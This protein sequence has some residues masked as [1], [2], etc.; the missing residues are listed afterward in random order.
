MGTNS[1]SGV[2]GARR[3]TQHTDTAGVAPARRAATPPV[4]LLPQPVR[5]FNAGAGG[6]SGTTSVT[7]VNKVRNEMLEKTTGGKLNLNPEKLKGDGKGKVVGED[8]AV[9][10]GDEVSFLSDLLRK[11]RG[12]N[13]ISP[14]TELSGRITELSDTSS[15]T[16][17]TSG[18]SLKYGDSWYHKGKAHEDDDTVIRAFRRY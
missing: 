10:V 8:G 15:L 5:R 16:H 14:K 9:S 2:S 11:R 17:N 4:S 13:V 12:G 6:S 1:F 3:S 7:S 18:S